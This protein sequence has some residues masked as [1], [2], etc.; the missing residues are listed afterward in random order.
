MLGFIESILSFAYEKKNIGKIQIFIVNNENV[1][2]IVL[3]KYEF[4]ENSL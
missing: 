2:E 1:D 3:N 4:F